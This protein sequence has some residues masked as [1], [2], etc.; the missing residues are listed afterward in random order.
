MHS[1]PKIYSLFLVFLGACWTWIALNLSSI[2]GTSSSWSV[3]IFKNT[4]G[5]N[6]PSCGLTTG[7]IYFLKGELNAAHQAHILS[8]PA[9]LVLIGLSFIW[10]IDIIGK[11]RN[12]LNFYSKFE[13]LLKK[14]LYLFL[15]LTLVAIVWLLNYL[16]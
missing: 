14:P 1:R 2:L 13:G 10:C 12:L 3:C 11:K 5:L 4:T 9:L 7:V 16:I 8:L 6:C 15:F